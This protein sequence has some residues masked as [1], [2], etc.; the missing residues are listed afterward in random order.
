MQSFLE[1]LPQAIFNSVC[2]GFIIYVLCIAVLTWFQVKAHQLHNL[3]LCALSLISVSF[4]AD[5]SIQYLHTVSSLTFIAI[6]KITT[7]YTPAFNSYIGILYIVGVG[8]QFAKRMQTVF[9]LH[10]F[11]KTEPLKIP[12][13]IEL[14]IQ[15]QTAYLGITKKVLLYATGKAVSMFTTGVIKPVIYIP[16]QIFTQ[17]NHTQIEALLIHEL[18]HIK[19]K[20]YWWNILALSLKSLL[21]FNPFAHW[22]YKQIQHYREIACDNWVTDFYYNKVD[23]ANALVQLQKIQTNSTPKLA[24]AF[25]HNGSSFIHRVK[26]IITLQK[27]YIPSIK[28]YTWL[29]LL[30]MVA[31]SI[32]LQNVHT[33][34]VHVTG[35]QNITLHNALPA[36]LNISSINVMGKET[37][38]VYSS[39]IQI[40]KSLRKAIEENVNN[41]NTTFNNANYDS[42]L[43]LVDNTVTKDV[44]HNEENEIAIAVTCKDCEV[45]EPAIKE[46]TAAKEILTEQY[47]DVV[48]NLNALFENLDEENADS[49]AKIADSILRA[50]FVN[51]PIAK[52]VFKQGALSSSLPYVI[53][54]LIKHQSAADSIWNVSYNKLKFIHKN[55]QLLNQKKYDNANQ[56]YYYNVPEDNAV[57]FV[58]FNNNPVNNT[59]MPQI[60]YYSKTTHQLY[61]FIMN[62]NKEVLMVPLTN[63]AI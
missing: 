5:V 44:Q 59:L 19:R 26:N 53:P 63:E 21:F 27:A 6:Q 13:D 24:M 17:L 52:K 10:R 14:F 42:I 3:F 33:R 35:I 20:D 39:V 43:F 28:N 32:I 22:L 51:N 16:V 8:L 54:K 55:L 61:L 31:T 60:F 2:L 57:C 18:A 29:Y 30:G 7:K 15:R 38:E 1:Y 41:N 47:V 45:Q 36:P 11:E 56:V 46:I 4:L 9:A 48:K 40:H 12:I 25:V 37:K 50:D 49:K 34:T 62:D 23:Y 58:K